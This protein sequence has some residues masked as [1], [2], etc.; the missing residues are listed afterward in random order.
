MDRKE[1]QH[2]PHGI[3]EHHY[4]V[5]LANQSFQCLNRGCVQTS[6]QE[7]KHP[8]EEASLKVYIKNTTRESSGGY[9]HV[10]KS[11][12]KQVVSS[13]INVTRGGGRDCSCPRSHPMAARWSVDAVTDRSQHQQLWRKGLESQQWT[14]PENRVL[15]KNASQISGGSTQA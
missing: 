4:E 7:P 1:R 13:R 8:S 5:F 12:Y 6:T 15:R 10:L 11:L 3:T 2:F 9:R 14:S